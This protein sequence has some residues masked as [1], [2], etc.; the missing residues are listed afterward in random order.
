MNLYLFQNDLRIH[1]QPLLKKALE[2]GSVVGLFVFDEA[3]FNLNNFGFKKKSNPWLSFLY[4]TLLDLNQQLNTLNI[5]LLVK[6]GDFA[7]ILKELI[8]ELN[9]ESIYFEKLPGEE[10]RKRYDFISTLNIPTYHEEMKPLYKTHMLP[11]SIEDLPFV[12]TQFRHK[13]ERIHVNFKE[14]DTLVQQSK[15][16]IESDI[17]SLNDLNILQVSHYIKPGESEGLKH[18][19]EY[20]FTHQL[21][22]TYKDTRNGMLDFND[23]TKFSAYLSIGSL[24][25]RRIMNEVKKYELNYVKNDSTYWIYF[26]LLWRDYFYFVH[27]KYDNRI[28]NQ[29]GLAQYHHTSHKPHYITAWKEGKTGY[30]LI[31][32]NI[33]QLVQTGYMSN[34]GRQ[35]VANFFTKF[36]NQDWRIGAAFFEAY[37]ID[38]DVSSNTLNWLYNAGLGND[39]RENRMFNY[40]TQGERYDKN[41]KYLDAFLPELKEVPTHLKYQI[42][43]LSEQERVSYGIQNYPR[44]IKKVAKS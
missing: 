20:L 3:W 26:E 32:A 23:S 39:P 31:D 5:P 25:V 24:S 34:R 29:E 13:I 12:F 30:P 8:R 10:E 1:D 14:C 43:E 16:T 11:F 27:K 42:S 35:N 18:L 40:I 9:I 37:L 15:T 2:S 17:P 44:P 4:D 21:A 7:F 38:Y 41:C 6:K 28:F 22:K 36:L 19:S 33:R